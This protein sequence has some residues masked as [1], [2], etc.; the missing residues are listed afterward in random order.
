MAR[1]KADDDYERKIEEARRRDEE[2][3]SK[4]K[5]RR[6][7]MKARKGK[8]GGKGDVEMMS[9]QEDEGGE[10]VKKMKK[11]GPAKV[12]VGASSGDEEEAVV[13]SV[14]DVGV[15]IHDDD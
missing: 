12:P 9:E 4:N 8:K 2:K 10:G 11:L 14:E 13:K 15:V 5:K 1:E 6:E 7:K 3:T